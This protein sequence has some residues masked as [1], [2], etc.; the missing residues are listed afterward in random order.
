MKYFVKRVFQVLRR[1]EQSKLKRKK[2]NWGVKSSLHPNLTFFFRE[3]AW[4]EESRLWGANN[5]TQ[6]KYAY[7]SYL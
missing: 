1:G 6:T 5:R 2:L 3:R 7:F 4:G